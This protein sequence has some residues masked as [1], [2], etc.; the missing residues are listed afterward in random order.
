MTRD[1]HRWHDDYDVPGSSLARRLMVVRGFLER[2]LSEAPAAADGR[3]RL[4]SLCAG[5]GRDVLPV[6]ARH[7]RG[8]LVHAVLAEL[9][10]GLSG[11]ARAA[12]DRWR[13]AGVDVRTGDA[14]SAGLYLDAAPAHVV[15]ACGVFGNISPEDARRT[16]AALPALLA[17]GGI[18]IW[19]RGRGDREP[20][21]SEGIRA[22]LQQQGFE[23][24]AFARPDDAR[25]RVGMHRLTTAP[26]PVERLAGARLF[27]FI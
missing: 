13:L 11:T 27:T 3:R 7:D 14:G 16:I 9:D 1:W 18:V 24:M 2:A 19:T 26:A 5:D 10:P 12:A 6:L 20:D 15:L 21:A 23:Q 8:R 4:I 17:A 22:A 25:F